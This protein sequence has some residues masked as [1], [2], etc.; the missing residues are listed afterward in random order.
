KKLNTYK[1]A[2]SLEEFYTDEI[3]KQLGYYAAWE[4]GNQLA[5]GDYGEIKDNR[6]IKISNI[7]SL[8]LNYPGQEKKSNA[9]NYKSEG[10]VSVNVNAGA[11]G[12]IGA[13]KG[14]ATVTIKFS[15]ENAV[16]LQA[17]NVT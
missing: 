7:K 11:S 14:E 10:A 9:I 4:P 13:A 5:I 2:K 3:H 6:F 8:K 16:L 15:K 17:K 12:N 1:M